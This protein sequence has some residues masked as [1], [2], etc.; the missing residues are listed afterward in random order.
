[1]AA[2]G[3][4]TGHVDEGLPILQGGFQPQAV[5]LIQGQGWMAQIQHSLQPGQ[6]IIEIVQGSPPKVLRSHASPICTKALNEVTLESIL[7]AA[8]E[9]F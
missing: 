1:M 9:E 7:W 4:G 5:P 3:E 6:Q 8:T 2:Q